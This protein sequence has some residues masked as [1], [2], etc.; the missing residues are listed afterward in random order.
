MLISRVEAW[1]HAAGRGDVSTLIVVG[2]IVFY[3]PAGDNADSSAM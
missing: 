2:V 3:F 1:G